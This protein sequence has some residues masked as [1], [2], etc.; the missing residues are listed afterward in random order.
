MRWGKEGVCG[1]CLKH[2]GRQRGNIS[3][4][5]IRKQRPQGMWSWWW[6]EFLMSR[7]KCKGSRREQSI[8]F[9]GRKKA[10]W[11]GARGPLRRRQIGPH[12]LHGLRIRDLD[13]ILGAVGNPWNISSRVGISCPCIRLKKK[14]VILT[15]TLLIGLFCNVLNQY[16]H[17]PL[18]ARLWG[19]VFCGIPSS[20]AQC[21]TLKWIST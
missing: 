20:I 17:N 7:N 16:V 12:R 9:P 3:V 18:K 15:L 14:I 21:Y 2:G 10:K 19:C 5:E 1:D 11:R 8:M 4:W 6:E 13:S